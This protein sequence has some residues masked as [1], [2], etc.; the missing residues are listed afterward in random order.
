M[1]LLLTL[2]SSILTAQASLIVEK[3]DSRIGYTILQTERIDIPTSYNYTVHIINISELTDILNQIDIVVS[4]TSDTQFKE[5]VQDYISKL[6]HKLFTLNMN[7]QYRKSRGL[8]NAVGKIQ[9][10]LYGSM[11]DEDRQVINE[12]LA[13][14]DINN[15]NAIENLNSQVHINTKFID[16]IN[17]LKKTILTD[18]NMYTEMIKDKII[19]KTT[20]YNIRL[21]LKEIDDTINTLQDNVMF[22]K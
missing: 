10:W 5:Y 18:R 3:I 22:S 11:D 15:H 4:N 12:H 21:N 16:S 2:L 14:I 13:T 19:E 7:S 1:L 8:L 20:M 6:E 17:T 9:K